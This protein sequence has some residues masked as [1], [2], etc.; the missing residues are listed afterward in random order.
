M[1]CWIC[2]AADA[3]GPAVADVGD[4]GTLFAE[5]QGGGGRAQAAELGV[6]RADGVDAGV[7]LLEGV[8]EGGRRAVVDVLDVGERDFLDGLGAGL[9]ADRVP[10]HPVGHDEQVADPL[11]VVLVRGLLDGER[12]LVVDSLHADVGDA[13]VLDLFEEGHGEPLGLTDPPVHPS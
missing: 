11:P 4:P 13:A 8:P 6:G 9:L 2:A 5:D 3:V 1:S 12:V 7:R 10:A